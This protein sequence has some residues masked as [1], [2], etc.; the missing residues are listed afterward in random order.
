MESSSC[1]NIE[2]KSEISFQIQDN[3]EIDKQNFHIQSII[4]SHDGEQ[5]LGIIWSIKD[6]ISLLLIETLN[7]LGLGD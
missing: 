7:N 4:E 6:I 2:I 5:P 3:L 1:S